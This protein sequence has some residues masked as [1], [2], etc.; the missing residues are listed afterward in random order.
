MVL[1][2]ISAHADRASEFPVRS[3]VR[4]AELFS[5]SES[6]VRVALLRLTQERRLESPRRGMY[7]LGQ[8]AVP[9]HERVSGWRSLDGLLEEW[10]GTS[11][12]GVLSGHLARSD[13]KAVR[14][15]ER[16]LRLW[17][18]EPLAPG[19]HVR[20][21]NLQGGR[22]GLQRRLLDLGLEA[23]ALVVAVSDL[24]ERDPA[25]RHLWPTPELDGNYRRMSESLEESERR[26]D[27]ME[28]PEAA[29]ETFLM[30]R[31]A[32][33]L[34]VLDPLLPAPLVDAA[35]R[36]RLGETMTRYDARGHALW[37]A[38]LRMS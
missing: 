13:R 30:G 28:L 15:R 22:E 12:L 1:E 18:L 25:A 10:D 8:A 16:A 3:L 23:Q 5:L 33:R 6:S 29:R 38:F 24:G 7:R 17:G 27:A 14:R 20:P 32:L 31:E 37:R 36:R 11:W 2:L 4:A 19:L 21:A 26:L 35:E 34:L 9:V